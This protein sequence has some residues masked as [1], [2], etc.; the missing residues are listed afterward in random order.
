[1]FKGTL[2][3]A[4][5]LFFK[6]LALFYWEN[7][8]DKPLQGNHQQHH[9]FPG[10]FL[11]QPQRPLSDAE[12]DAPI[13]EGIESGQFFFS[14]NIIISHLPSLES[15]MMRFACLIFQYSTHLNLAD[16]CMKKFKASP[17]KI[18]EVEQVSAFGL[19]QSL[20][21]LGY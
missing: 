4:C 13:P 15:Y 1:M 21:L 5:F 2:F 14:Y 16:A 17:E 18:C 11:G 19:I 3:I 12:E 20:L 8:V 7:Q 9:L 6:P 10:V